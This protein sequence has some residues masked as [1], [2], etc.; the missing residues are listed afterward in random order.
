MRRGFGVTPEQAA[1]IAAVVLAVLAVLVVG[2]LLEAVVGRS[3]GWVLRRFGVMPPRKSPA[4]IAI[5]ELESR[6]RDG[7]R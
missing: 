6:V 7:D 2:V 1:A 5:D 4:R 3:V